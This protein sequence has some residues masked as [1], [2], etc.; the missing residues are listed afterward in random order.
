MARPRISRASSSGGDPA[1]SFGRSSCTRCEAG[2]GGT[3][4]S[5]SW[6]TASPTT[7]RPELT[8]TTPNDTIVSRA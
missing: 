1:R 7:T 6:C 5:T 8:G 3:A 4:G 2:E